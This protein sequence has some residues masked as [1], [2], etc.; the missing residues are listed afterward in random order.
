ML[1]RRVP[2][3]SCKNPLFQPLSR[4]M[5]PPIRPS[6]LKNS[7][8]KFLRK[9]KFFSKKYGMIKTF[10]LATGQIFAAYLSDR[11]ILSLE[12]LNLQMEISV[13]PDSSN[14]GE[15][16][17]YEIREQIAFARAIRR[18]AK[19]PHPHNTHIEYLALKIPSRIEYA[20]KILAVERD[21]ENSS[22]DIDMIQQAFSTLK[23]LEDQALSAIQQN[24]VSYVYWL[25]FNHNLA[26]LV[27]FR[28]FLTGSE[29]FKSEFDAGLAM[30]GAASEGIKSQREILKNSAVARVVAHF[31]YR[32]T[33][34]INVWKG[35]FKEKSLAYA[36][37]HNVRPVGVSSNE[38]EDF[39]LLGNTSF[40]FLNHDFYH[41]EI[42]DNP[43]DPSN[44][45]KVS[46]LSVFRD[47]GH[48]Q[49]VRTSGLL[50]RWIEEEPS[51][52]RYSPSSLFGYDI[53]GVYD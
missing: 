22:R 10:D 38:L 6:G 3:N 18:L 24:K 33:L 2:K 37:L 39:E 35:E 52:R 13:D 46:P 53:L 50:E 29:V 40:G 5:Y 17:H 1:I 23:D 31:P 45:G 34:P 15:S 16:I 41:L 12:E 42:A 49:F 44:D 14:I 8:K 36:V 19:P 43:F 4:P 32:I 9:Q 27:S 25:A 47:L 26:S 28:G 30:V 20:R 51:R 7:F 48:H 11:K 21:K